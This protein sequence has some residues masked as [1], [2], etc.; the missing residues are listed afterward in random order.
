M[1]GYGTLE[2]NSTLV[3]ASTIPFFNGPATW[4]NRE[5]TSIS[6]CTSDGFCTTVTL[7]NYEFSSNIS[8]TFVT[9]SPLLQK[10]DQMMWT[11]FFRNKTESYTIIISKYLLCSIKMKNNF[12]KTIII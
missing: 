6:T 3:L 11:C 7:K 8:G 9:I 10:D 1:D 5:M 12:M 4:S 2:I